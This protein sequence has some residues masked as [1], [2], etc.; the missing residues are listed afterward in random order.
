MD[1]TESEIAYIALNAAFASDGAKYKALSFFSDDPIAL[2]KNY[3]KLKPLLI[4]SG[5]EGLYN[6]IKDFFSDGEALKKELYLLERRGERCVTIASPLY[7]SELCAMQNPPLVLYARGNADLLKDEKFA[8]VGSRRTPPNILN[9]TEKFAERLSRQ[10]AIVT[11]IA[12]GGDSAALSGALKNN[13]AIC[14]LPSGHGV[15]TPSSSYPL[16]E[17]AVK[18]G[19]VISPFPYNEGAKKYSFVERNAIIAQLSRGV[20][21]VS[22]GEKSGALSTANEALNAGKDVFAFPYGVG[23]SSGVGCNRLIKDGA[24]LCDDVND[25][26]S[27]YGKDEQSESEDESL[28][29]NERLIVS[30]LTESEGGLHL[31]EIARVTGF[32]VATLANDLTTLEI[33]GK[34]IRL[35]GNRYSAV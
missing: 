19:L 11:G 6:S 7:P 32:S 1:Y 31:T 15:V 10:F 5:K 3:E 20:L 28:S 26:L 2:I 35:G 21:V 4:N 23:V 14:V 8:V 34:I 13:R 33:K 25:I 16:Y 18:N 17:E 22:A 29:E 12:D 24:T 27:F 30:A 9:L